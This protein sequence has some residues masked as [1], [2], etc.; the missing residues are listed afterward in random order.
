MPNFNL[1][2]LIM[3]VVYNA[4][5]LQQLIDM[6]Q[7]FCRRILEYSVYST[8]IAQCSEQ[9]WRCTRQAHQ[10]VK[11]YNSQRTYVLRLHRVL[12]IRSDQVDCVPGVSACICGDADN[13]RQSVRRLFHDRSSLQHATINETAAVADW[14]QNPRYGWAPINA[15]HSDR[16]IYSHR[17]RL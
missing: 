1:W 17:D 12:Y 3:Y 14:S 7:R 8:T 11:R 16:E 13:I 9:V 5:I 15:K 4:K 2:A 6:L 10:I